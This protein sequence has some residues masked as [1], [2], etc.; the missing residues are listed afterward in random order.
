MPQ[1]GGTTYIPTPN[2]GFVR[3]HRITKW[4]EGEVWS[5]KSTEESL[6]KCIFLP[7]KHQVLPVLNP[8]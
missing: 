8:E 2:L 5:Y 6:S 4:D 1:P 7:Y 3:L